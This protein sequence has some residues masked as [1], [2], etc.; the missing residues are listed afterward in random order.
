M[1][2][3]GVSQARRD[4]LVAAGKAVPAVVP[5]ASALIDTGA[6]CTC[7]DRSAIATLGLP[8][9]G[10]ANLHTPSTGAMPHNTPQYDVQLIIPGPT[11][12]HPP[13]VFPTVP[14]IESDF[15]A[16]GIQALIGRDILQHCV[17]AYVG[18]GF[19][20]LAY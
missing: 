6:S 11:P 17:L 5:I 20:T 3:I 14:I 4:A 13:L 9:T 8:P 12:G 10:V 2:Y 18:A 19:F 16:Q 1:A 15:S 7:I